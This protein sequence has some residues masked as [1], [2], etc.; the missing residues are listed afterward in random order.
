MKGSKTVRNK[1][2]K[3]RVTEDELGKIKA[4]SKTSTCRGASNYARSLLLQKPVT[5]KYRNGSADDILSEMIRLKNELNAIGNNF[6][7]AVHRLHTLDKIPEIK[8]WLLQ[9]ETT[10]QSFMKKAEEIRIR[11]IQIHEQWSQ[12]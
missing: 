2:F 3:V 10:R 6:N 8:L 4:F 9:S 12:K 1:W 11:M 5:V 7:Q